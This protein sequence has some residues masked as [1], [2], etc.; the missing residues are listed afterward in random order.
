MAQYIGELSALAAA[1]SWAVAAV[2]FRKVGASVPPL[3]LNLYKGGIASVLLAAVI[4]LNAPQSLSAVQ[5]V[6][7]WLVLSGVIGIGVGDTAFFAALNRLGER[8]TLLIAETIAPALSAFIAFIWLAERLSAASLAGIAITV[9]GVAWVIAE[10]SPIKITVDAAP[11]DPSANDKITSRPPLRIASGVACALIA[12]VSQSV[13]AVISRQAFLTS[14][15]GP[16]ESSLVRILGG[17]AVLVVASVVLRLPTRFRSSPLVEPPR[18]WPARHVTRQ[19]QPAGER[20]GSAAD[21]SRVRTA[22]LRLFAGILVATLLGTLIGILLQQT[23]LKYTSAGVSQT[24]IATSALFSILIAGYH[25][26]PL[27][28]RSVLGAIVAVV[29]IAILFAA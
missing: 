20:L 7:W 4:L 8:R 27:T 15:I 26:E 24:L 6:L 21:A 11:G 16:M 13:G 25:G 1:L 14:D 12:A 3:L 18:H 9:A 17:L 28:K 2:L 19:H 23:S 5:P 10:R 22:Q 29:G